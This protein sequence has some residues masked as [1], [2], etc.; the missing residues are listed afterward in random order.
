[1]AQLSQPRHLQRRLPAN[2]V[3]SPTYPV[4]SPLTQASLHQP[5]PFHNLNRLGERPYTA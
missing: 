5:S 2:P 3:D 4:N 1:M